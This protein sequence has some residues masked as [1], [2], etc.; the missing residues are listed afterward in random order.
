MS[1]NINP[2]NGVL[3]IKTNTVNLRNQLGSDNSSTWRT[4]LGVAIGSDVQAHDEELADIAGIYP[5]DGIFIVGDS[6]DFV[7][8]TKEEVATLL[9]AVTTTGTATLSNKTLVAPVVDTI[10]ASGTDGRV[11]Y[12]MGE[13][14]TTS[15][16]STNL[17]TIS[18]TSNSIGLI[19]VT[20]V[21]RRQTDGAP[22]IYKL[23]VGVANMNGNA[24]TTGAIS[25]TTIINSISLS[26]SPFQSTSSS[27]N[28]TIRVTAP[29]TNPIKFTAWATYVRTL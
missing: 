24:A 18:T 3:N 14:Q 28:I 29:D 23:T 20:V 6:D 22:G 10:I 19:E 13:C 21:A 27:G 2:L 17:I 9:G 7:P 8:K 11:Q 4:S 15:G 5:S 26:G 25:Q 16:I 1:Q 12:S